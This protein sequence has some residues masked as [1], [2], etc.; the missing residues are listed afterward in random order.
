MIR[1][2]PAP[3]AERIASSRCRPAA[4]VSIRFATFAIAMSSTNVTAPIIADVTSLTSPGRKS[5][6]SGRALPT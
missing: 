4:R 6:R 5:S 2:R 1:Y 3:M